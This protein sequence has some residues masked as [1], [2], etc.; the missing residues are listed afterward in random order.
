MYVCASV[1]LPQT[2]AD[3][4]VFKHGNLC[5]AWW[6]SLVTD[7]WGCLYENCCSK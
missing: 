3:L 2:L 1:T 5:A 7:V 4:I 6:V